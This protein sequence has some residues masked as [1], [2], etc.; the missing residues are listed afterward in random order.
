MITFNSRN[1]HEV[2]VDGGRVIRLQSDIHAELY[3]LVIT[4]RLPSRDVDFAKDIIQKPKTPGREYWIKELIK[5]VAV[6][7]ETDQIYRDLT[8]EKVNITQVMDMFQFARQTLK[9]PKITLVLK[10]GMR[11]KFAINWNRGRLYMNSDGYGNGFGSINI[12]DGVVRLTPM[13]VQFRTELMEL[14]EQFTA[15]PKGTVIM[16]GKLTGNCGFCALGLTDPRS[17]HMGYGPICAKHWKLPWG[18][19][20]VYTAEGEWVLNPSEGEA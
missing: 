20:S 19:K 16:H 7:S 3:E 11:V 15:D 17:L 14:L 9:R 1:G 2:T 12:M 4:G 5:R 8:E 13:G 18:E 6:K 10:N